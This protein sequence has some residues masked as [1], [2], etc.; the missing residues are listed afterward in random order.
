MA[1]RSSTVVNG[2]SAASAAPAVPTG[3]ATGDIAVVAIYK[4]NAA[5]ITAPA[6]FTNKVALTTSPTTQGS[7]HVYWK[8]LTAADSGTYSFTWTGSTWCAAVCGLWSGRVASGDPFDGTVGTAESVGSVSTLNVSTSPATASGDAVGVW[9]NFNGGAT[10]TPPT[11]YTER[12]DDPVITLDTRDNVASGS[13][14]NTTATATVSDFMKAFLGVLKVAGGLS[15]SIGTALETDTALI[16]GDASNI[17]IATETD[18]PSALG[19][20][21][22]KVSGISLETDTAMPIG[23]RKTRPLGTTTETETA[24]VILRNSTGVALPVALE[25]DTAQ[26]I[27]RRKV[28]ALGAALETNSARLIEVHVPTKIV[29]FP[30]YKDQL[31]EPRLLFRYTKPE[32]VSLIKR[33]GVWSEVISPHQDE[34]AAAQGFY[35]GGHRHVLTDAQAAD[36]PPQYVEVIP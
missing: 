26:S 14:G 31:G 25:T 11:N 28:K 9:T 19:R 32:P 17:L 36:L 33:N 16:F 34:I 22:S 1:F 27:G 2:S 21:K 3:A 18:F 7:L 10:F 23:R 13:T 35:Q 8:R 20:L 15:A 6:G 29:K 30:N 12:H 5:A 24:V 4:E